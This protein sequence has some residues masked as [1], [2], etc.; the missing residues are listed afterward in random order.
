MKEEGDEEEDEEE[1][2]RGDDKEEEELDEEGDSSAFSI[3]KRFISLEILD[4]TDFF[5]KEDE[6]A[7]QEGDG[8]D[9]EEEGENGLLAA[10]LTSFVFFFFFFNRLT[11]TVFL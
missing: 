4:T 6:K 1:D 7:L 5:V 10:T 3:S 2:E 8:I 9:G 11:I